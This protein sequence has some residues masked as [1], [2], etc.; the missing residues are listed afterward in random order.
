MTFILILGVI[1]YLI[2]AFVVLGDY[3]RLAGWIATV[4]GTFLT[5]GAIFTMSAE[6][7]PSDEHT[8]TIQTTHCEANDTLTTF[9]IVILK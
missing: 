7:T 2:G 6:S 3:N 8:P 5:T 4:L 1:L 9:K